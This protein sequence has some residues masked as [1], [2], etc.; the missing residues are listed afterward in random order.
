MELMEMREIAACVMLELRRLGIG[1][2][3]GATAFFCICCCAVESALIGAAWTAAKMAHDYACYS[4]SNQ[5]AVWEAM[6]RALRR[7]G[8]KGT[9]GE[10]ITE[11]VENAS[12]IFARARG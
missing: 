12:R 2:S 1:E 7:A 6:R 3:K 9:T 8:W 10:A 11:V 5:M 4:D